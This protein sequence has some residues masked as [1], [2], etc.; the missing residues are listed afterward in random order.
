M[1]PLS[2]STAKDKIAETFKVSFQRF[3]SRILNSVLFRFLDVLKTLLHQMPE[4]NFRV[5]KKMMM[6]LFYDDDIDDED[7]DD[8]DA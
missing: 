7:N 4:K 3:G 6:K 1:N 8:A 2:S 5:T